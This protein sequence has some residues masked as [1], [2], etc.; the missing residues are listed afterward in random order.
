LQQ[1]RHGLG[2]HRRAAI[3][4][5]GQPL[6]TDAPPGTCEGDELLRERRAFT[7][8]DHPAVGDLL[9]ALEARH[10]TEGRRSVNRR[11]GTGRSLPESALGDNFEAMSVTADSGRHRHA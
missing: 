11:A 3:R 6:R 8:G 4:V 1:Q 7:M 10:T 9:A 2:R 5:D